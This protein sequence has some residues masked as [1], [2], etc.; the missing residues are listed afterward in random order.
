MQSKSN[1]KRRDF[2]KTTI[3]GATLISGGA[4]SESAAAETKAVNQKLDIACVGTANQARFSIGNVS[5]ENIVAICDID[6]NYLNRAKKDFPKA[7]AYADYR[8][9]IESEGDKIDAVTVA[10]A[11]HNHAPASIRAIRAGKHVYCEKP[12][13]HTVQESRIIAEAA[14]EH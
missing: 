2:L 7:R 1:L 6:S 4:W 10:I 13:T 14:K 11:D 3:L 8:E 12:L 9:L 5:R